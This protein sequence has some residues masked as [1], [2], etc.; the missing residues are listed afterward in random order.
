MEFMAKPTIPI[1]LFFLATNRDW[2]KM[3]K[4]NSVQ[5]RLY[6]KL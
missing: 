1:W 6:D 2:K 5:D 3:A 4:Q